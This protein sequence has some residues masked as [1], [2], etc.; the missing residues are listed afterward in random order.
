[1]Y[2]P[3]LTWDDLLNLADYMDGIGA[4]IK[5]IFRNITEERPSTIDG[6]YEIVTV[7]ADEIETIIWEKSN[8]KVVL[9]FQNRAIQLTTRN[10]KHIAEV[11]E[12]IYQG[13]YKSMIV[14]LPIS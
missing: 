4:D 6:L 5:V 9:D 14:N 12:S 11:Y 7:R 13:H 3:S 10:L 8:D 1:M 2:Q